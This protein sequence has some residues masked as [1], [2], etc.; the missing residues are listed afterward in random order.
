MTIAP[1]GPEDQSIIV[2]EA[3]VNMR[4]V[5]F[6]EMRNAMASFIAAMRPSDV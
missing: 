2:G 1:P 4:S 6:E 3:F 5:V